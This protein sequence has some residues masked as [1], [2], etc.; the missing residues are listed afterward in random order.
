LIRRFEGLNIPKMG[1][2]FSI[3]GARIKSFAL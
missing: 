1:H 2:M 3:E